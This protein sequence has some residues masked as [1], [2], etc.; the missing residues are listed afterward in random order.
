[1]SAF[2]IKQ[3]IFDVANELQT[4]PAFLEKDFYVSKVLSLL[5][6][7]KSEH[8]SLVFGGGTC[9]LKAHKIIHRFSEDIDFKAIPKHQKTTRG[10]RRN[11]R[12]LIIN[13]I[14][15][16]IALNIRDESILSRD[17]SRFFSSPIEYPKMFEGSRSMRPEIKLEVT[18]SAYT[19]T[20]LESKTLI[21]I[22]GE[23]H[24]V[25]EQS[26][27]PCVSPEVIMADKMSALAWRILERV[28][29]AD[30]DDKTI[31]RHLYDLTLL[32]RLLK[33]KIA[34]IQ[35]KADAIYLIDMSRGNN[36]PNN[37]NAAL[38]DVLIILEDDAKYKEEYKQF[39]TNMCF[40]KTEPLSFQVAIETL[41]SLT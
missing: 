39:V 6:N 5:S 10:D 38:K 14:Q 18:F 2:D 4:L 8:F 33:E 1:M 32:H 27:I 29:D 37:L 24:D 12:R 41:K 35:N 34:A 36:L 20:L 11:F 3:L 13:T 19:D 16:D 25:G 28:R 22:I 21:P 9:L 15:S 23:Y 30:N 26:T 31:I 7:L 40:G 17:E